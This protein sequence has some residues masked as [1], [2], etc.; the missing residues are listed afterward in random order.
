MYHRTM[1]QQRSGTVSIPK[2]PVVR[3]FHT[4]AQPSTSIPRT[5]GGPIQPFYLFLQ[6]LK[7]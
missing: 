5:P 6:I 2:Q 7:F 4:E 3:P 1:V